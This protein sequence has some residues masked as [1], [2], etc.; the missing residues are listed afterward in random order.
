MIR[1]PETPNRVTRYVVE[2]DDI[3]YPKRPGPKSTHEDRFAAYEWTARVDP[4]EDAHLDAAAMANEKMGWTTEEY[5]AF[6]A[7]VMDDLARPG[8]RHGP[9]W[10]RK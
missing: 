5:D 2:P 7:R 8:E 10:V 1:F 3:T 6:R 4:F 9:Y